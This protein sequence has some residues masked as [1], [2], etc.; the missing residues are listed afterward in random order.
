MVALPSQTLVCLVSLLSKRS[1]I[2]HR[3]LFL[4]VAG[5]KAEP[6]VGDNGDIVAGQVMRLTLSCD[7]RVVDGA[8][9]AGFMKDLRE[10][11]ENPA[12]LML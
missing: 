11:L 12:S 7:H 1:L 5:I 2:R 6:V 10:I 4:A 9:A 8:D 3:P